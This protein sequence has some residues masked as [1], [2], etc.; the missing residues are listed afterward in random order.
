MARNKEVILDFIKTLTQS[1]VDVMCGEFTIDSDRCNKLALMP[2]GHSKAGGDGSGG[3]DDAT[4]SMK[5][6]HFYSLAF[7]LINLLLSIEVE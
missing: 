2:R 7:P 3:D 1:V 4:T 6:Q 5:T